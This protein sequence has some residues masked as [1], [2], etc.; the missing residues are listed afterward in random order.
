MTRPATPPSRR[1]PRPLAS[2]LAAVAVLTATVAV[3]AAGEGPAFVDRA[4]ELGV[5]FVHFNGMSG[6]LYMVENMG[7]GAGLVDYDGDGDL[8]LYLVQGAM[9]G[10]GKTTA[11]ALVPPRHPEP[12]SDRLYRN[13]LAAGPD[14]RPEPRFVDVTGSSGLAGATG[15]GM[16]VASGD[17]DGDGLAD[18]YLTNFGPNQLWHNTGDGRFRDVTAEAGVD[19]PRWSVPASF[20]DYDL[21]GRLDLWV[22][23]YLDF[24][25]A[26]HKPCPGEGGQ[27]DYC[28]PLAYGPETDR[29]FRNRG[30]GGFEDVTRRAGLAGTAGNALGGIAADL[31]GDGRVDLYVA[32]DMNAN[33]LWIN[34]GDGTFADEAL[35]AG[36]ALDWQGQP[37]AGMGVD[38]GDFDADGDEDLFVTHLN[39]QTNTLYV[40]GGDG[41]F[42]DATPGSGLDG[43]SWNRTGFGTRWLDYDNDGWLDLLT[44]NGAVRVLPEQAGDPLPLKQ[45]NQLFRNLG[46]GRFADAS[47]AA[48]E[49]FAR[50]EASRGAAFGDLDNDGDIDVLIS[51]NAGPARLLMNLAGGRRGW[52][53][54]A[55]ADGTGSGLG[56]RVA[57]VRTAGPVLWRRV[58][59]D[60]S[61]ASASDPRLTIGLGESCGPLELRLVRPGGRTTAWR[62]LPAGRYLNRPGGGGR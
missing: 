47:A 40:N 52:L 54:V 60:G 2:R 25:F 16:G 33:R 43:P 28:G 4:A 7:A 27:P 23:N 8:D 30:D 18:L 20:L 21:D 42:R 61:Y 19:D 32:N 31:D 55:L 46:D 53:G 51:N 41:I 38:A 29:L 44:A 13:D 9:L 59:T 57:V 14:G 62:G 17:Y 58:H 5:D 37:Q 3:P 50:L 49:E 15:Y 11:D 12:L 45:P 26:R 39:G 36:S 35:L 56:S 22:G 10:P 24:I 1:A 34:R 6:E 48:G